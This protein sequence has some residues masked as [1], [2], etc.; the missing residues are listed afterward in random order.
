M[1]TTTKALTALATVALAAAVFAP[2]ASA[3]SNGSRRPASPSAHIVGTFADND[4]GT[5][6]SGGW[7]L[8]SNGLV[9]ALA[10]APNYGS[11]THH[12]LN[13]FVGMADDT[14]SNGY[15]L[16]TSTGKVF[17]FGTT[18]QDATLGGHAPSFGIV[19]AIDQASQTNEGF[20]LVS[21]SGKLYPFTCNMSL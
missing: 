13:N 18:C 6:T 11:A 4:S 9:E 21:S 8:Y 7:I 14:Q 10:G 15:W 12:G 3:S 17:S 19:G 2:V 1:I 16:V 20:D 5:N